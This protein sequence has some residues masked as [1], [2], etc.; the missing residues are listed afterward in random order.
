MGDKLSHRRMN[1]KSRDPVEL[2]AEM[3]GLDYRPNR[4]SRALNKQK[5]WEDEEEY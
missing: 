2:L 1:Q 4:F 5:K 3:E